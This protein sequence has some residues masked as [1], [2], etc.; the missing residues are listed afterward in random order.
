MATTIELY[1]LV[2]RQRLLE[3][4]N[5]S[6]L[7]VK[8]GDNEGSESNK[9]TLLTSLNRY[10]KLPYKKDKGFKIVYKQK[11]RFGRY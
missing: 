7:P 11:N 10:S 2:N 1:E 8:D 4:L 6:N 9:E 5:C 3:V